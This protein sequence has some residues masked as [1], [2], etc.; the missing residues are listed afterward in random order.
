VSVE[1]ALCHPL[2]AADLSHFPNSVEL[3]GEAEKHPER[4]TEQ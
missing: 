4:A 2:H 1:S 3:D